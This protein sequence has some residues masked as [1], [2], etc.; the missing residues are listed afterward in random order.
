MES[1]KSKKTNQNRILFILKLNE[2][3]GPEHHPH[4]G[5]STGLYNS[6]FFM[7]EMLEEDHI[8]SKMV[9]VNDNNDIDREVKSYNPTHVIIEALWVVPSKFHVLAKLHPNVKWIIRLHSEIPFLANEGIAMKWLGEYSEHTN[10]VIA[11]NSPQ[12][13]EDIKFYLSHRNGW[14]KK[15]TK[16]RVAFLPNFYPQGFKTKMLDKSKDIIDIACFGAIRPLKNHLIQAMAAIQFADKINKKLNFHINF[17]IQ[18]K[19][20]PILNNLIALFSH[21]EHKGHKLVIHDWATREEFLYLC[22]TM[23][24]GMQVSLN[25]TF[26]IVGADIVSQGVPLVPS[27][28]I[29]W[30]SKHFT[31]RQTNTSDIFDAICKTYNF[32]RINV[33]LNQLLLKS[34]TNKSRKIWIKY[35]N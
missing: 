6:S 1:K 15:I 19:G 10:V 12:A 25:E 3:Y 35:F 11:C 16:E 7:S 8:D 26:N 2:N 18:Q 24:I 4:I 22:S 27:P 28:E 34:Y 33:Y 23:D 30:A 31:T 32:P 20:E 14:N 9:V 21:L 5:L 13:T 17:R 29:P